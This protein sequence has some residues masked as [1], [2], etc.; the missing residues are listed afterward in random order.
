ML[1]AKAARQSS[2]R[3]GNKSRVEE[4]GRRR[5][6]WHRRNG[7]KPRLKT[8]SDCLDYDT[9]EGEW[10]GVFDGEMKPSLSNW[11]RC[12]Q[13]QWLQPSNHLGWR[14]FTVYFFYMALALALHIIIT[15]KWM[16][17]SQIISFFFV[18]NK[19]KLI[20]DLYMA[21]ADQSGLLPDHPFLP[22]HFHLPNS[23]NLFFTFFF[24]SSPN[25]LFA[26]KNYRIFYI[27]NYLKMRLY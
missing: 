3:S 20:S 24:L 21:L 26:G 23:S 19:N 4:E 9:W 17:K 7:E 18:V 8:M 27:L 6:W 25:L 2:R 16:Y 14:L 1:W 12:V 5:W 13:L 22:P 10:V 15:L 11:I